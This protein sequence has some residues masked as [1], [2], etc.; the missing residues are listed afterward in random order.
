MLAIFSAVKLFL[1][2]LPSWVYKLLAIILVAVALVKY[3]EHR[4]QVEWDA[5][6]AADKARAAVVV[7]RQEVVTNK[8]EA[9]EKVSEAEIKTVFKDR[10]IYKDRV[11]THET[12]VKEDA[13]CAIPERFISMWNSANSGEVPNA[14]S[15]ADAASSGS[16]EV[17]SQR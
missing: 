16:G 12:I 2:K 1:G 14:S 7:S 5:E 17:E 15:S 10:I 4:T 8:V 3:G 13:D 11:V 6:K 9:D